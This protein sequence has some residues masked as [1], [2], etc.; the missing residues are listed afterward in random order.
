[1]F[2]NKT[3][4]FVSATLNYILIFGIFGGKYQGWVIAIEIVTRMSDRVVQDD[5]LGGSDEVLIAAFYTP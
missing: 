5:E 2:I 1:M 3:K 4:N